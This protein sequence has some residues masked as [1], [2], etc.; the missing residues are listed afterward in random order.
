MVM[1]DNYLG[2][3]TNFSTLFEYLDKNKRG[4]PIGDPIELKHREGKVKTLP[5]TVTISLTWFN[6]G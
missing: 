3:F 1:R 5:D 6:I 2:S 4:L